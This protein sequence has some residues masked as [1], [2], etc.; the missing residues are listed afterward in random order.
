M[1]REQLTS[2]CPDSA[3]A[4]AHSGLGTADRPPARREGGASKGRRR[5]ER[6]GGGAR[7]RGEGESVVCVCVCVCAGLVG[8]EEGGYHGLFRACGLVV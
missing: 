6:R 5:D 7:F 4:C 8:F 1:R 2:A 3:L